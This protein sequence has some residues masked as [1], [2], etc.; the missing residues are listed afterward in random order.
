M[1][2]GMVAVPTPPVALVWALRCDE[3]PLSMAVAAIRA[4]TAAVICLIFCI[5]QKVSFG[6]RGL[7]GRAY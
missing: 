1:A 5:V 6:F 3:H 7:L 4:T 2:A